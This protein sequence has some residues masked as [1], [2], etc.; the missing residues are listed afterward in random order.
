ML[1]PSL[2]PSL[3]GTT[4]RPRR[5]PSG[6]QRPVWVPK[7]ETAFD[8]GLLFPMRDFGR[9]R[10]AITAGSARRVRAPVPRSWAVL[11]PA[12]PK[13]IRRGHDGRRRVPF[14]DGGGGRR[15]HATVM[16][17]EPRRALTGAGAL[18]GADAG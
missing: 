17:G 16:V 2:R 10:I 3:P 14:R 15:G 5:S 6:R 9:F 11:S 7:I 13:V 4:S 8:R 12:L 1:H 18:L